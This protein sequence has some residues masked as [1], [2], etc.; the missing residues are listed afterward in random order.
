MQLKRPN[1][2]LAA[3][4]CGLTFSLIAVYTTAATPTPYKTSPQ[5]VAT[6]PASLD[7]VDQMTRAQ[8][9]SFNLLLQNYQDCFL[10]R[11][12]PSLH[13]DLLNTVAIDIYEKHNQG[14]GGDPN[15]MP[16]R[17]SY[18]IDNYGRVF[19]ENIADS[20]LDLQFQFNEVPV[21]IHDMA[22][23][24]HPTKVIFERYGIDLQK[25]EKRAAGS[26][27]IFY[28][29]DT[30]LLTDTQDKQTIA[31]RQQLFQQLLKANGSWDFM[32]RSEDGHEYY[33]EGTKRKIIDPH[34]Y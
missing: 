6:K 4:F 21:I 8:Q 28:V 20:T 18:L 29:A 22:Q 3:F 7:P 32:L 2:H 11:V 16:R 33:I 27:V 23:F 13:S 15:T 1:R 25:V 34:S 14:C 10:T 19:Y 30:P 5:L 12:E 31:T 17:A 9:Y 26:F 24:H